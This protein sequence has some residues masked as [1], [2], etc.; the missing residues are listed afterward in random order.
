[1]RVMYSG[2]KDFHSDR[3][4]G[5]GAVWHGDGDTV[6]IPDEIGQ[7][8]VRRHPDCYSEAIDRPTGAA[9]ET[10]PAKGAVETGRV[11]DD[12]LDTIKVEDGAEQV[13]LRNASRAA[14]MRHAKTMG[15]KP[16]NTATKV[17][18]I[19]QIIR[20]TALAAEGTGEGEGEGEG[21]GQGEGQG[22]GEGG[23]ETG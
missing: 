15:W 12:P 19:E 1:M 13:S 2:K 8:M 17:D 7:I 16:R 22:E 18:L 10:G 23:P 20:L 9:E 11:S 3:I 21:E 14:L 4:Y 5:T 6:T